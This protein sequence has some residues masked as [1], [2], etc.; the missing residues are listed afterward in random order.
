MLAGKSIT[1]GRSSRPIGF[2]L[3]MVA[4]GLRI[5]MPHKYM[6]GF[7]KY[8]ELFISFISTLLQLFCWPAKHRAQRGYWRTWPN[9]EV[10]QSNRRRLRVLHEIDANRHMC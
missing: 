2:D 3:A 8:G 4:V 5:G 6:P 7:K 10:S 9:T 1:S